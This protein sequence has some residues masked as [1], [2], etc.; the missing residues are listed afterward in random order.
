MFDCPNMYSGKPM[1][2]YMDTA[3]TIPG[4]SVPPAPMSHPEYGHA[5]GP[6]P[7]QMGVMGGGG[8]ADEVLPKGPEHGKGLWMAPIGV[9]GEH[10]NEEIPVEKPY[11]GTE[12][13]GT[14]GILKTVM[15]WDDRYLE[16]RR[17]TDTH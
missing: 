8:W 4:V 10:F 7:E 17:M 1:G 5:P 9:D 14:D 15:D 3:E 12:Y 6:W 13:V 2:D 11:F 16:H